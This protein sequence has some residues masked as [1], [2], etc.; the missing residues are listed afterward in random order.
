MQPGPAAAVTM[1]A[2]GAIAER[3]TATNGSAPQHRALLRSAGGTAA[4]HMGQCSGTG[5]RASAAQ[6]AVAA[7]GAPRSVKSCDAV[8]AMY[9]FQLS[10]PLGV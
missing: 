3:L 1:E 7:R 10:G 8:C 9:G 5:G 4:G 2:T 6:P